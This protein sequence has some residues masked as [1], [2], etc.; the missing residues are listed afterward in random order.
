MIKH[1]MDKETMD[2][3]FEKEYKKILN[4]SEYTGSKQNFIKAMSIQ[5]YCLLYKSAPPVDEMG[6]FSKIIDYVFYYDIFHT[7]HLTQENKQL[8]RRDS[9]YIESIIKN[10]ANI[11]LQNQ[12]QEITLRGEVSEYTPIVAFLNIICTNKLQDIM[13]LGNYLNELERR[14]AYIALMQRSFITIKSMLKLISFGYYE[15]AII[16]WRSLYENDCVLRILAQNISEYT[17]KFFEHGKFR[18]L[19]GTMECD[20]LKK[21]EEEFNQELKKFNLTS[22]Q[23][24]EFI[25][26]GWLLY[27]P[28][29]KTGFDNGNYQLNFKNGIAK[30][31]GV[32]DSYTT[33]SQASEF[34]HA[35]ALSFSYQLTDK[36]TF[37]IN[38]LTRILQSISIHYDYYENELYKMKSAKKE[39]SVKNSIKSILLEFEEHLIVYNKKYNLNI[40][41]QRWIDTYCK[42]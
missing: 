9:K 33:Y 5:C 41:I 1:K 23:K 35:T 17:I 15:D 25:N 28:D 22:R 30:Y 42:Y 31:V 32:G 13:T 26:F 40:S 14:D 38:E 6:S 39:E 7:S 2:Y 11:F 8:L 29:F 18:A 36:Y 4:I 27:I 16:L 3:I 37:L 20:N 21:L 34:V 10:S 12:L 24:R 19:T